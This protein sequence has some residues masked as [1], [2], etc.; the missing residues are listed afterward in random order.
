MPRFADD[1]QR[2]APNKTFPRYGISASHLSVALLSVFLLSCV[3]AAYSASGADMPLRRVAVLAR[4][5]VSLRNA[6]GSEI[7]TGFF[8][9]ATGSRYFLVTAS[10]VAEAVGKNGVALFADASDK[11]VTVSLATLIGR[12]EAGWIPDPDADVAILSL[13][14]TP[15]A[16]A[17]FVRGRTLSLALLDASDAAPERETRLTVIGF[18]YVPTVG[19]RI[20]ALTLQTFPASGLISMKRADRGTLATFFLLQEPSMGGYSGAPVFDVGEQFLG[21]SVVIEG[22]RPPTCRG[23]IHGTISDGTGGKLAAVTPSS[24]VAA[25]ISRFLRP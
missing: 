13:F 10:H 12:S 5:V 1:E 9:E 8:V 14:P 7:G 21:S 4:L 11:P 18:P 16:E 2:C 22:T 25:L 6:C 20:S 17:S 24:Y 19:G 3:A 15:Q 23:V